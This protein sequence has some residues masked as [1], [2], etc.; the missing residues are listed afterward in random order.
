MERA[1]K[2][3]DM[4]IDV[5][6]D[7]NDEFQL[8]YDEEADN[9]WEQQESEWITEYEVW[10]VMTQKLMDSYGNILKDKLTQVLAEETE[11]LAE[12]ERL[13]KDLTT[14][15]AQLKK[16]PNLSILLTENVYDF[17]TAEVAD[18]QTKS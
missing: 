13:L 7:R 14:F 15:T 4:Y 18:N 17:E 6:N 5:N 16:D 11:A 2:I 3:I 12:R 8:F 9:R 10:D 1:V